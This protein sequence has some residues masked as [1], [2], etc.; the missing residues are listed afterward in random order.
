MIAARHALQ[1]RSVP[2]GLYGPI[3]IIF[4]SLFGRPALAQSAPKDVTVPSNKQVERAQDSRPRA[5]IAQYVDFAKRSETEKIA[6]LIH[7]S[8]QVIPKPK[9]K[10]AESPSFRSLEE[11]ERDQYLHLIPGM[12]RRLNGTL[13]K[14]EELS[15]LK[16]SIIFRITLISESTRESIGLVFKLK[17]V[18]KGTW[19]IASIDIGSFLDP[20]AEAS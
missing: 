6:K 3:L 15:R 4:V 13:E 14:T 11:P 16:G 1:H 9:D 17:E 5:V 12:I 10:N 8:R 19:K 18:R 20:S 7:L 2:V